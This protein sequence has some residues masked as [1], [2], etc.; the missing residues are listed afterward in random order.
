MKITQ[1]RILLFTGEGKGKTT[2]ALGMALRAFGH[3]MKV[4]IVYFVKGRDT[5][6]EVLAVNRLDGIDQFVTGR[7]FLPKPDS[8]KFKQHVEAAEEGY[9]IA[10]E[11]LSGGL[12]DLV[13]LDEI[14][15]AVSKGLL[16][17]E[18]VIALANLMKPE[19]A[20]VLTGRGATPGLIALADTVT[21]MKMVKHGY[22]IGIAAQN[23]IEA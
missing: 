3:G 8:Y 10:S 14:C 5:V 21:E 20:L 17:E 9:R 1:K 2:A 15:W 11:L 12:Y 16:S 13:I 7:G 6:G 23:G 4:A 19:S 18:S 22:T